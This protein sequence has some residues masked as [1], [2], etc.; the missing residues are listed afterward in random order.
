MRRWFWSRL[1]SLLASITIVT[2][3][4]GLHT[5]ALPKNVIVQART[6][7][8]QAKSWILA[9]AKS[10]NLVYV[11]DEN[12]DNVYV[13]SYG[14]GRLVGTL[15]GFQDPNGLCADKAGN[16]WVTDFLSGRIIEY[17]HGGT[18]P[19]ATLSDDYGGPIA[20]SVDRTTGNL[21]VATYQS[22]VAVYKKAQGLPALFSD[23]KF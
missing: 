11:S 1:A 13:F 4:G 7:A 15:K 22:G 18:T 8:A 10:E 23:S 20:C 3:C 2:S 5:G 14:T 16:V 19:I 6:H 9:Q 21:G 12:L 17:A